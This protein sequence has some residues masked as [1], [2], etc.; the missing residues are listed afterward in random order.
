MTAA[1]ITKPDLSLADLFQGAKQE[2][3]HR[4]R[5]TGSLVD[6]DGRVCLMGA[7][8]VA[9]GAFNDF[10]N[11]GYDPFDTGLLAEAIE[12]LAPLTGYQNRRANA[13]PYEPVWAYN[14]D[15]KG[16][17]YDDEVFSL[18]DDAIAAVA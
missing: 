14:D 5:C 16:Q 8:G 15:R 18:L 4:G 17:G 10:Y 6:E 13:R 1:V 3:A 9:A 12:V 11:C 7:L 2:L